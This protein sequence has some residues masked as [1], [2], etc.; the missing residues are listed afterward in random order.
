[1]GFAFV[2]AP[3]LVPESP[4][5]PRGPSRA[6]NGIV[7]CFILAI[8]VVVGWYY[9]RHARP[10]I[11]DAPEIA[12]T[13]LTAITIGDTGAQQQLST[14]A[15]KATLVPSWFTIVAGSVN[16]AGVVD[17]TG[18]MTVPA[19]LQLSPTAGDDQCNEA[20]ISALSRDYQIDIVLE[21]GGTGWRVDQQATF[22]NM[23]TVLTAN[24]PDVSFPA[25]E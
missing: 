16:G 6:V 5:P 1:M 11:A 17:G 13:Y 20:L 14:A 8:V 7:F 2:A 24:N 15:S 10:Q 25:W 18:A 21:R 19:Q 12:Q 9:T 3:V 23:R 22:N 4:A